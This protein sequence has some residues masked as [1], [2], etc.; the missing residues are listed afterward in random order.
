MQIC[1]WVSQMTAWWTANALY[2]T[3]IF[4]A[5]SI[6]VAVA[7]LLTQRN[8]SRSRAAFDLFLKAELDFATVQLWTSH[9]NGIKAYKE[10]S[11]PA[12]FIDS[13]R[14]EFDAILSYLNIYELVACGIHNRLLDE[15]ICHSYW[16]RIMRNDYHT[17]SALLSYLR[18]Q[19]DSKERFSEFFW[20]ME[21]P[22]WKDPIS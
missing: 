4:L 6:V 13:H 7:A 14:K 21:K 17:L 19:P 8:L 5:V 20:L 16:R 2:F 1:Q 12:A 9:Q 10:S 15:K 3:P 18:K 11:D 22:K